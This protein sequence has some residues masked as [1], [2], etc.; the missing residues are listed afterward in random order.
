[1]NFGIT[2]NLL[3]PSEIIS[4]LYS[5]KIDRTY[6]TDQFGPNHPTGRP[7]DSKRLRIPP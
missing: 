7:L 4:F 1:M 6:R 5:A 3:Y 2:F